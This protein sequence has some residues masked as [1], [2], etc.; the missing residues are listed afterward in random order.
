MLAML[1]LVVLPRGSRWHFGN[2][3]GK[4]EA[5]FLLVDTGS[6]T[7]LGHGTSGNDESARRSFDGSSSRLGR[8]RIWFA[9]HSPAMRD[10]VYRGGTAI[11]DRT[12]SGIFRSRHRLYQRGESCSPHSFTQRS[13]MRHYKSSKGPDRP[14]SRPRTSKIAGILYHLTWHSRMDVWAKC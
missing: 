3:R 13:I 9:E 2:C 4:S 1:F 5:T 12:N 8:E 7:N 14:W 6:F 11:R 10:G